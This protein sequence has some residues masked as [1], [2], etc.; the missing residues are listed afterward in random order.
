MGHVLRITQQQAAESLDPMHSMLLSKF[1]SLLC[2]VCTPESCFFLLE[3][4]TGSE[5]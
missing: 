5:R 4:N 2:G 3:K 1:S